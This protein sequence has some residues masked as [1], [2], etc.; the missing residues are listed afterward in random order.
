M[1]RTR[2]GK[3]KASNGTKEK[4]AARRAESRVFR[5]LSR[6][7]AAIGVEEPDVPMKT[8]KSK[9]RR[10]RPKKA[11]AAAANNPQ[12]QQQQLSPEKEAHDAEFLSLVERERA[13]MKSNSARQL[14][15]QK[16]NKR[17][18]RR[19]AVLKKQ[20]RQVAG[21]QKQPASNNNNN[22]PSGSA[23][24]FQPPTFSLQ[25]STAQLVNET[26]GTLSAFGIDN[27]YV[28]L[29]PEWTHRN[30]NHHHPQSQSLPQQ[31]QLAAAAD[32]TATATCL[33]SQKQ[34]NFFSALHEEN[35]EGQEN[36]PK[37]QPAA[38][39]TKAK[40][41]E[42]R[43]PAFTVESAAAAQPHSGGEIDPDL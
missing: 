17:N 29:P 27:G 13:A 22:R 43:P 37:Q 40:L 34:N 9:A 42:F 41:F 4:A 33:L 18:R 7:F 35:A 39:T 38:R 31:Q 1:A 23:L 21:E 26:A 24:H 30:P 2:S 8:A 3:N 10:K 11:G 32:A 28:P 19:S 25:K 15:R 16:R 12:Q 14:R 5:K 36:E 20:E 6:S